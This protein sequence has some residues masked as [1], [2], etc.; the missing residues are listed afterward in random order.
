MVFV[1]DI[2]VAVVVVDGGVDDVVVVVAVAVVVG[3]NLH[4]S[5]KKNRFPNLEMP[6]NGW[7]EKFKG[8]QKDRQGSSYHKASQ[9]WHK[10]A[11]LTDRWIDGTDELMAQMK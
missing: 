3:S 7:M 2:V 5:L 8:H 6:W 1:V 4:S 11:Q 10:I 9:I